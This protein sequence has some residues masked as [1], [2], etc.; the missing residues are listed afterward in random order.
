M[1]TFSPKIF[2]TLEGLMVKLHTIL[3]LFDLDN[4]IPPEKCFLDK[5]NISP[6]IRMENTRQHIYNTKCMT[7]I[8]ANPYLFLIPRNPFTLDRINKWVLPQVLHLP[9]TKR[10]ITL[11]RL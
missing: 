1:V 6:R 8:Y 5:Q 9:K 3:S 7:Y 4:G 10:Y 2:V 11:V